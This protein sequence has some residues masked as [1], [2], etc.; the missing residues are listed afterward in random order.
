[1]RK[2]ITIVAVCAACS[3]AHAGEALLVLEQRGDRPRRAW[4]CRRADR[5]FDLLVLLHSA[6]GAAI[7]SFLGVG[8][9]ETAN[10]NESA[11]Y[12]AVPWPC[13]W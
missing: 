6:A 3:M 11:L 4:L 7:Y 12:M 13:S 2:L 1:M 10:A 5:L 8:L 9:V